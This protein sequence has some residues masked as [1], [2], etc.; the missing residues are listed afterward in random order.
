MKRIIA[1]IVDHPVGAFLAL[2]ALA[3]LTRALGM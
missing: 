3:L 2:A 1:F